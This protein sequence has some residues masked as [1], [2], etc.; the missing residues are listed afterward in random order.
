MNNKNKALHIPSGVQ[1]S[2]GKTEQLLEPLPKNVFFKVWERETAVVI[3]ILIVY[4]N[5]F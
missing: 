4:W 5:S 2:V 3:C 1:I